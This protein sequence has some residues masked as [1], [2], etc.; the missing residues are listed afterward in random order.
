MRKSGMF[1]VCLIFS[2][3]I[4]I[5]AVDDTDAAGKEVDLDIDSDIRYGSYHLS[6]LLF[7]LIH[8]QAN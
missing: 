6:H 7:Q 2:A 3:D 8:M 1:P 5:R 4:Y